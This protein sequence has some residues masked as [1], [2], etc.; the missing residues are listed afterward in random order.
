MTGILRRHAF[1][2]SF[3]T[4]LVAFV[5][6]SG[7]DDGEILRLT[8]YT[9][10]TTY[11]LQLVDVPGDQPLAAISDTV[12]TML[13]RLDRQIFST[14][15]VDSELSRLNRHPLGQP[16][17]VS[18]EMIDV[19]L[20]AEEIAT[21]T[22]GAFDVTVGPL[23]NLWGF[24]P[25]IREA[26]ERVPG[27]VAIAAAEARVGH[28]Y[29]QVDA[30]SARVTRAR[31]IEVD[32]SA[33]AKGYA[34]D[35][36]GEYFDSL[37]LEA[38]FLEIGGELKMKGLKPGGDSWIPAIESPEASQTRIY[39]IFFSRGDTLAVAGSGDYRNY[40]EENGVRYSHEIDPRTG[41][42]IRHNL[43]AVYVVD[44]SAARA[45]ALATALMILGAE[46]GRELAEEHDFGAYFISKTATGFSDF[47]TEQFNYYLSN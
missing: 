4:I 47:Y 18:T 40:F 3:V 17:A 2:L 1:S 16:F 12:D 5:F 23:V 45:D 25:D 35:K 24:G 19:L 11:D 38:Y 43:A 28:Q 44:N 26:P 32:L 33:I 27:E 7:P 37:G 36:L 31:D 29:L 13:A 14:Y 41:R 20:M 39:E 46:Q 15:A 9:M 10:G 22:G 42:P 30:A 6:L 34:V 21:L 8:G